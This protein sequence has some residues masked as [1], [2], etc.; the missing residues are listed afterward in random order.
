MACYLP[1]RRLSTAFLFL[2]GMTAS[3][4]QQSNLR[5]ERL[6]VE[7]G[8]PMGQVN[9]VMQD[10]KGFIWTGGLSG[11][12]RYDG[13]EVIHYV[14]DAK[15]T[16]SIG[17]NKVQSISEALGGAGLWI[18][19]QNGLNY[20]DRDSETFTR[21]LQEESSEVSSGRKSILSICEIQPGIL[22]VIADDEIEVFDSHNRLSKK[23]ALA[24]E[25]GW[26]QCLHKGPTDTIWIGTSR[27]LLKAN[28]KSKNVEKVTL[29][30]IDP[31]DLSIH[32]IT[33]NPAGTLWLGS[34]NGIIRYDIRKGSA[35]HFSPGEYNF[36]TESS[37]VAARNGLL[38]WGTQSGLFRFD[39]GKGDWQ[40][41]QQNS[42]DAYSLSSSSIRSVH[43]DFSGNIWVST[44]AGLNVLRPSTMVF[45]RFS[46]NYQYEMSS[47]MELRSFFEIS[48]GKM[49]LWEKTGLTVF[50]W[51]EGTRTPFPYKPVQNIDA[52]NT[53]VY[54]FFKDNKDRIWM[55]TLA[56]VFVFD[57]VTKKFTHYHNGPDSPLVL[58]GNIIRDICQDRSGAIWIAIWSAGVNVL[59]EQAGTVSHFLNSRKEKATL[60][61]NA[62]RVFQDR[63]GAMWVGT[64]GGLHKY[65]RDKKQFTRFRHDP[66][67]PN[68]MGEN[69]AFDIYEDERGFLWVGTYGGGLNKFDPVAKTFKRYTVKDGLPDNTVFSI[70]PDK[71]GQLWVS[72]YAGL[73]AFDP[74][75][76]TFKTLDY[77]DG[78]LNK[79]Y[80]AYS[81]YKSPYSGEHIYEGKQG[82]DIFHPDSIRPDMTPPVVRF[83]GFQLFNR[84]VPIR[85]DGRRNSR[86]EYYLDR[87]ISETKKLVIPYRM[88]VMT[89]EFAALHFANPAKNQYAYRLEGFD[90]DWQH[91]GN[92]RSVTFTN[93]RPGQYTLRVK[94]SN[95]DGIWNEEGAAMEIV[96]TPPWWL[97]WWAFGLYMLTTAALFYAY[98]QYRRRRWQIQS[99]LAA[100]QREA[101]RLQELDKFKTQL[102][103][104][105]THE[106]RTPLTVIL[107]LADEIPAQHEKQETGRLHKAVEMVR[108]NSFRLLQIVNQILDLSKLEAGM[109]RVNM[110]QADAVALLRYLSD[111]YQSLADAKNITLTFEAAPAYL[112]MDIDEEKLTTIYSNLLSNAVKFTD[113]GGSISIKVS[114]QEGVGAPLLVM[115]VCD[116]GIGIPEEKLPHVFERFY[117]VNDSD[118][119]RHGLRLEGGTGIGL[120]LSKELAELLGGTIEAESEEGR[121][122]C[123]RVQLPVSNKAPLQPEGALFSVAPVPAG[124]AVV[125]AAE[126][127]LSPDDLPTLLIVEDSP[128]IITYLRTCLEEQYRIL[129]ATNGRR[130]LETAIEK[131]PDLIISDV[132]MPEMDGFQLCE[133]LKNDERTSHIPI[134]L[135]TARVD[136]E[137]RLKGLGRG[138]DAYLGKPFNLE[139]LKLQLAN[140]NSL[141]QK[142]RARYQNLAP[143]PPTEDPALQIE[144]EFVAKA[145][146]AVY[147]HLDDA[148]FSVEHLMHM[149]GVSRTQLHNKLKALTGR[150]ATG[151]IRFVRLQHARE[152]LR[153]TQ[154]TVAEVAYATGFNSPGYFTRRYQEEFGEL[155]GK[156]K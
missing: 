51:T 23:L 137:S 62:R 24:D 136:A 149:L 89:F 2:W 122:A 12:T 74:E 29:A 36:G 138:A 3:T 64:R 52:W 107:G 78:V 148:D 100:Q 14:N 80:D 156:R 98:F 131:V 119:S 5:V 4:A 28:S 69:T 88:K 109:L 104:N 135:L 147:D 55:G 126:P 9:V 65:D 45:K 67:D 8:I 99:E 129:T 97:T 26:M 92:R 155:P 116:T 21:F 140:L 11:L 128:D 15:D 145:R 46:S 20:F 95:A 66:N 44:I 123:F 63:K 81:Y 75:K 59:D 25:S 120:T 48:P 146:Q 124:R 72:T 13:Y 106:F 153:T 125:S 18:V 117:Q 33:E 17:D 60:Q 31:A 105:F 154:K 58:S 130:G 90:K 101:Q 22:W 127:P 68:S 121:G 132:M 151:F 87:S 35:V 142:L 47:V 19:T 30:G 76:E 108:R 85:R 39:P 49:L 57:P 144:D 141:Q 37:I 93:L 7:Q 71:R 6:G 115:E 34:N 102:Y 150:S 40:R 32:S 112:L 83:S 94:A 38:W 84:S 41:F 53:G 134:A 73:A 118:N 27:G 10:S 82:I 103:A 42:N 1:Y 143:P 96:I 133:T 79:Q 110:I 16:G 111:S 43:E 114:K 54:C 139:E 91:I 77:R 113:E 152:L 50:D 61:N 70:L 56:G 86:D